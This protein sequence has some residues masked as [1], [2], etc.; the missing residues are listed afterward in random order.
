EF[1]GHD[2]GYP[3]NKRARCKHEANN[4]I[5]SINQWSYHQQKNSSFWKQRPCVLLYEFCRLHSLPVPT[6]T[7]KINREL[8]RFWFDCSIGNERYFSPQNNPC[9]CCWIQ[10]EAIDHISIQAFEEIFREMCD[11]DIQVLSYPSQKR[12][13]CTHV[14]PTPKYDFRESSRNQNLNYDNNRVQAESSRSSSRIRDIKDVRDVRDMKDMRD[15][16]R[17]M[18]D[19][20]DIRDIRDIRDVKDMKDVRDERSCDLTNKISKESNREKSDGLNIISN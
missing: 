10:N 4:N 12:V 16:V 11:R 19:V 15:D 13:E 2:I 6:Y 9:M 3:I 5:D 8:G 17:D 18:R 1:S 14:Q 20:R 7:L